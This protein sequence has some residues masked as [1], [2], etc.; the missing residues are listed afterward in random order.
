MTRNNKKNTSTNILPEVQSDHPGAEFSSSQANSV[1]KKF[2]EKYRRELTIS[3]LLVAALVDP[4]HRIFFSDPQVKFENS[5]LNQKNSELQRINSELLDKFETNDNT[6]SLIIARR[7]IS[8]FKGYEESYYQ[9]IITDL[10]NKIR[11]SKQDN[12]FLEKELEI[13][14]RP[15]PKNSSCEN[16]FNTL[17]NIK[18]QD[19]LSASEKLANIIEKCAPPGFSFDGK[20]SQTSNGMLMYT[21]SLNEGQEITFIDRGKLNSR[22]LDGKY[23]LSP[24]EKINV[25]VNGERVEISGKQLSYDKKAIDTSCFYDQEVSGENTNIFIPN[26]E[27]DLEKILIDGSCT[28]IVNE[29]GISSTSKDFFQNLEYSISRVSFGGSELN[30]DQKQQYLQEIAFSIKQLEK[31]PCS[32]SQTFKFFK[33]QYTNY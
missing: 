29:D 11:I 23:N 33:E 24:T 31:S 32:T 1:G 16:A 25:C 8:D 30:D 9:D 18:D 5:I 21:I 10:E 17:K 19:S 2:I 15:I 22:P 20:Y 7:N 3:T 28:T 6:L 26:L 27:G 12:D 4:L 13:R 14:K